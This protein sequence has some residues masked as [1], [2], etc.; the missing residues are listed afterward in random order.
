MYFYVIDDFS[1]WCWVFFL[2]SKSEAFKNFRYFHALV[3]R[4]IGKKLKA[5][6]S[7][8]GGEFSPLEFQKYYENL[9]IR[10]EFTAPYTPQNLGVVERNNRA[11]VEMARSLLKCGNLPLKFWGEVVSTAIYIINRSPTQVVSNKTPYEAWH[12]VKPT[13]SYLRV[14]GCVV[15]AL[16]PSHKYQ[17]LNEKSKKCLFIGYCL[18]SKA[19]KLFNPTTGKVIISR[20]VIFH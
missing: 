4:Q 8:R 10:K 15:F 2:K 12:G 7:D 16:I 1:K 13:V 20:D 18:E 19:C 14:F 3:E 9:D 5:V 17:K 11:L 6:R